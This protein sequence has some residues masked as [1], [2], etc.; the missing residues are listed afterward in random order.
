MKCNECIHIKLCLKLGN[1]IE[2][3]NNVSE[4]CDDFL[5]T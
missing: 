3:E 1:T 2:K 5:S 4:G